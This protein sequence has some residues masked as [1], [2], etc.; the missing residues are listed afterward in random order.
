M[1]TVAMILNWFVREFGAYIEVANIN[2][3]SGEV[4]YRLIS[5]LLPERQIDVYLEEIVPGVV[6][7][8]LDW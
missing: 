6:I 7:V 8:H 4:K 3:Y 2:E 1:P 5:N